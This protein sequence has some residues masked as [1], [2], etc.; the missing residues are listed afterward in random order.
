MQG[1]RRAGFLASFIV[2]NDLGVSLRGRIPFEYL[3]IHVDGTSQARLKIGVWVID[4]KRRLALSS[5]M[6][7]S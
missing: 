3:N 6:L 1:R 4:Y 7:G 2:D 5:H